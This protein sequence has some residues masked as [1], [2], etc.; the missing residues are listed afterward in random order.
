MLSQAKG[1]IEAVVHVK[2]LD[3]MCARKMMITTRSRG[4][5][6]G[7]QPRCQKMRHLL[8]RM[9][10]GIYGMAPQLNSANFTYLF[11]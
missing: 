3:D 10:L 6:Q 7:S 11:L 2:A 5:H 4:S 1:K 8:V 9:T